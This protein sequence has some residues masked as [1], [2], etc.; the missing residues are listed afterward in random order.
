MVEPLIMT[1]SL[2]FGREILVQT[3]TKT[4][5]NIYS[6]LESVMTSDDLYFKKLIEKT[7]VN[8]K[9][10]IMH[11]LIEDLN[12]SGITKEYLKESINSSLNYLCEILINIEN[13]I[14]NINEEIL[15]HK[16]KW[17][18]NFRT[19]NYKIMISNFLEHLEI[20]DKRFNILLDLLKIK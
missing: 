16:E 10:N 2:L 17:F 6:S 4:T 5:T 18:S 8:I 14:K 19:P 9:L 15:K 11:K 7:D 13:D 20:L 1:S 3:V 12:K